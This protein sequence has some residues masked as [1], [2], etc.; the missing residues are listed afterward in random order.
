MSIKTTAI[1]AFAKFLLG[2][3]IFNRVVAV[4]QRLDDED[5]S[6]AEKKKFALE[7]FKLIGLELTG[8]IANFA[9]EISVLYL[10]SLAGKV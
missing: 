7:Q 2:G 5:I 3:S 9:V 4:V 8:F 6:G 1:S 10:R